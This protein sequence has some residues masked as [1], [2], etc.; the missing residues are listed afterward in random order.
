MNSG[1]CSTCPENGIALQDGEPPIIATVAIENQGVDE[2]Y[3]AIIA[4]G[5]HLFEHSPEELRK[6]EGIRVRNQLLDL[7]KEGLLESAMEKIG[8]MDGIDEMVADILTRKKDPY[9]VSS[10][11]VEKLLGGVPS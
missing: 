3:H 8:G 1:S 6:A 11:L 10:E 4:H 9:G 7:L 5:R 2:L